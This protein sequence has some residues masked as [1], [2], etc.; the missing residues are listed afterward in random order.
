MKADIVIGAGYGDEGKGYF[1]DY[2][3]SKKNKSVVIR[4]NGGAQAGH[5]VTTPDNK[6]HVFGHFTSNLFLDNSSGYLSKYFQLNPI[7]YLKELKQLKNLGI[8]P[9][10]ACHDNCYVS[11]PYD[12]L[13]NQWLEKSRG[14]ERHGS[15][16]LG[17]GE[18]IHR[19]E[20]ENIPLFAFELKDKVILKNKLQKI[21]K[22]FEKRVRTLGLDKFL[23]DFIFF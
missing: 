7:V 18:T 5:T 21:K 20:V 13:L 6:T 11:T 16:G 9:E 4:F 10:M 15:C 2:I 1:T 17:I 3:S 14:D 22:Y 12:M 23:N 19:S 8:N